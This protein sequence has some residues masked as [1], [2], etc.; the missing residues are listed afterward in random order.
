[1]TNDGTHWDVVVI[2]GGMAGLTAAI[3]A[4]AAGV[5][6]LVLEKGDVC[7]GNAA[8]SAGMFL[9][10]T[11]AA[12][13]RAYIPDGDPDLQRMMCAEYRPALE[14]LESLAMP[15]GEQYGFGDFRA[16]R[17]MALGKPRPVHRAGARRRRRDPHRRHDERA[18]AGQ[19]R[20]RDID[21][22]RRYDRRTR[23]R[24]GD[25]RLPGRSR[26]AANGIGRPGRRCPVPSVA[27]R[28]VR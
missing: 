27:A 8:L 18:S 24:A 12:G 28:I 5:A 15:L 22:G 20:V 14:W 21:G 23:R 3:A 16:V 13:L 9:G 7:G 11:D 17:P 4:R 19:R 6:T 26:P 2:G 25:R 10:S 1:M